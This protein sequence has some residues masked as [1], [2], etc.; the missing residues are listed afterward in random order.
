[1]SGV[2]VTN[3]DPKLD[4]MTKKRPTGALTDAEFEHKANAWQGLHIAIELGGETKSSFRYGL[5]ESPFLSQERRFRN[6][7]PPEPLPA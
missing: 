3:S 6:F 4:Q 5:Q 7:A 2:G 1:V